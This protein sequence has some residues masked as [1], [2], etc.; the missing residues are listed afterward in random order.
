VAAG[1]RDSQ[2]HSYN[3]HD[4]RSLQSG[5]LLHKRLH[6][7]PQADV[8]RV[9]PLPAAPQARLRPQPLPPQPL[10]P[11]PLPPQ[12]R[13]PP[14]RRPPPRR[15]HPPRADGPDHRSPTTGPVPH[16]A[17]ASSSAPRSRPPVALRP[18]AP[19]VQIVA[20]RRAR[21]R[22]FQRTYFL[23]CDTRLDSNFSLYATPFCLFVQNVRRSS[24]SSSAPTVM[25]AMDQVVALWD[26]QM[27]TTRHDT[28]RRDTSRRD[29]TRTLLDSTRERETTRLD[30]ARLFFFY[31]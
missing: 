21:S 19:A 3:R 18:V 4:Y 30:T 29:A 25:L 13:R 15:P 16:E 24:G 10:P 8:P 9:E 11:Q 17:R 26:D 22:E 5:L 2:I 31:F 27:T 12:P 28:T 20:Q 1:N 7:R 6:K 23:L 14:P